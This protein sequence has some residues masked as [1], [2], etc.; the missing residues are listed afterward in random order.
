MV[1]FGGWTLKKNIHRTL[2]KKI[3]CRQKIYYKLN[4]WKGLQFWGCALQ[5]AFIFWVGNTMTPISLNPHVLWF[6]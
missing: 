3:F 1:N 6:V 5:N 4:A 2:E